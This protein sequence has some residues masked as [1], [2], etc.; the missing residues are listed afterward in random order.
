MPKLINCT[1]DLHIEGEP[2]EVA[3]VCRQML[4]DGIL[5]LHTR[6]DHFTWNNG[7]ADVKL[8]VIGGP[9]I[10]GKPIYP[11][12]TIHS[13]ALETKDF[14]DDLVRLGYRPADVVQLTAAWLS[15]TIAARNQPIPT[16]YA[17][18]KIVVE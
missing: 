2:S 6:G 15:A 16:R 11:R 14:S 7:E 10:N 12:T 4:E 3:D 13:L 17:E 9:A 5:T 1:I 8:Q 18:R